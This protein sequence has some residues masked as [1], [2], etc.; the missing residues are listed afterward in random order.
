MRVA[1]L[2]AVLATLAG[3]ANAAPT[4]LGVEVGAPM[5]LPRGH[6]SGS[7]IVKEDCQTPA[8]HGGNL[9]IVLSDATTAK[10][11][12]VRH[13]E[14]V[15]VSLIQLQSSRECVRGLLVV[16]GQHLDVADAV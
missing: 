10:V 9:E 8:A 6:L 15:T 2:S 16:V 13:A 7:L 14:A 5:T 3:A 4:V 1:I 11:S 12:F